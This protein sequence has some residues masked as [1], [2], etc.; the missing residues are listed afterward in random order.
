MAFFSDALAHSAFAG[1]SLGLISLFLVGVR[2][3]DPMFEWFVPLFMAIFGSVVGIGIAL[4]RERTALASDTVIGVFFAGA[5][6]IGALTFG[7]MRLFTAK[8]A[9]VFLFGSTN[10]VTAVHIVL[11][12]ALAVVT[13]VVLAWRY[14][15]MVFASFNPSLARSR[16]IPVQ[17]NNYVFII[18]LALIVNISIQVVGV[19]LINAMLLVPAATASLLSRNMRQM[20]WWSVSLSLTGGLLGQWISLNVRPITS[21]GPVDLGASG[22][23]IVL[24]VLAFVLAML[25]GPLIRGRQAKTS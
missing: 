9:E 10:I 15:Q 22:C 17:L 6:G 25:V 23:V 5:L 12:L 20:F 8:N 14:N 4:V 1:I 19:I 11:L 7:N 2:D 18:L 16:R 3:G 24:N 21:R 13:T